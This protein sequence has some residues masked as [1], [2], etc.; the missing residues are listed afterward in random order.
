MLREAQEA[1]AAYALN[2]APDPATAAAFVLP[3]GADAAA[4]LSIHR[5]NVMG[6]LIEVLADAFPAVARHCGLHNFEAAAGA[7]VRRS[8]PLRAQLSLFGDRFADFLDAYAPVRR[9]LPF[10]GDLA[11]LEWALNEAY[12]A[13]EARPLSTGRLAE[14]AP[15]SLD[16]LRLRLHPATRLVASSHPIYRLWRGEAAADAA[17]PGDGRH[18]L[19]VRPEAAVEAVP[20]GAG[21]H[22]FVSALDKGAPLAR[23]VDAGGAADDAFDLQAV[24]GAH[25]MRGTFCD[26]ELSVAADGAIRSADRTEKDATE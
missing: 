13:A 2:R 21:D 15:E 7:F 18:V 19:V 4:R 6:S 9:D 26:A 5:N 3:H 16:D 24:L 8:P 14:F 23:A 10:L 11:R 22:A 1:L 20:I 25:L 12:F 17:Q